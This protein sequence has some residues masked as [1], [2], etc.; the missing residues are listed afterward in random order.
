MNELESKYRMLLLGLKPL[1]TSYEKQLKLYPDFVALPDELAL[2]FDDGYQ[3][4]PE[5]K[6]AGLISQ[7]AFDLL[8]QIDQL[9]EQMTNREKGDV[10]SMEG[11]KQNP[12]WQECRALAINAL[13]ELKEELPE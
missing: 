9:L 13:M 12:V 4:V 3:L 8:S 5:L 6:D 7:P 11:F 2:D 10:W 1:A